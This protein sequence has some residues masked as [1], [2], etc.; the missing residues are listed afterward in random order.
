L[1]RGIELADLL[2]FVPEQIEAPGPV[3]VGSVNIDD[4]ATDGELAGAFDQRLARVTI[5]ASWRAIASRSTVSPQ[6]RRRS[7]APAPRVGRG[8]NMSA[9][10]GATI[11]GASRRPSSRWPAPTPPFIRA[12]ALG[13][14]SAPEPG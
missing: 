3:G 5:S 6:A 1:G 4:R 2:D 7:G 13:S 11:S 14:I 12:L 8:G 10:T 9:S